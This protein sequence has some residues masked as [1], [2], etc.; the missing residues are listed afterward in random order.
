MSVEFAAFCEL[1]EPRYQS[2]A[3]VWFPEH[4]AAH[5]VVRLALH[6]IA[7]VWPTVL[8]SSNPA[9]EA[10]QILRDTVTAEHAAEAGETGL[11]PDVDRDEDLAIL[12]YVV[13]LATPEIADVMGGD[14]ANIT[15][16]LRQTH[17]RRATDW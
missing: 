7:E 2:Y 6:A 8:E 10:W 13:G 5:R 11:R 1:H 4:G 9:A 12:H 16:Q 14:T 3:R 17:R 15:S